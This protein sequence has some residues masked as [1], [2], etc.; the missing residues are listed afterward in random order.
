MK[1]LTLYQAVLLVLYKS[2]NLVFKN[3]HFADEET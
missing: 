2:N 3:L 1:D